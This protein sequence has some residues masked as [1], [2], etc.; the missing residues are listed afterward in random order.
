M[1]KTV[2]AYQF[3]EEVSS[4]GFTKEGAAALF[5]YF[6]RYEKNTNDEEIEFDPIA[7]CCEYTE[8]KDL[9]EIAQEYG[10]E[11]GNQEY[12]EKFTDIIEFETGIIIYNF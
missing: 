6:E 8:Y 12:L 4:S 1:K 3:I 10:E 9:N 2:T 5:E 7:I 11:Y